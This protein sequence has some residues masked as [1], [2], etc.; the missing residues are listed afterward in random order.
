MLH[1]IWIIIKLGLLVAGAIWLT[2]RPGSVDIH[3]QTAT[4][5]YDITIQF[6]FFLFLLFLAILLSVGLTRGILYFKTLALRWR[7]RKNEKDVEKGLNAMTLSL[8]SAAAGD[9]GYCLFHAER[10]EKMLPGK[11]PLPVLLHAYALRKQGDEVQAN[12]LLEDLLDHREGSVLAARALVSHS[13]QKNDTGRALHYV[14]HAYD[15]YKGRDKAWL[16][17]TLYELEVR[18]R[19]WDEGEKLLKKLEAKKILTY[20]QVKSDR[21][22]LWTAK[23]H[24]L[25]LSAE[26]EKAIKQYKKVLKLDAGYVP[27]ALYVSRLYMERGE[28]KKVKHVLE[29][30]WKFSPH[31]DLADMWMRVRLATQS[32]KSQLEWAQ[33]LTAHF[34]QHFESYLVRIRAMMSEEKWSE[35]QEELNKAVSIKAEQRLYKIW[36]ELDERTGKSEATIRMRLEQMVEAFPPPCWTCRLTG[37]TYK[38]WAPLA[39]PHQSFN[40]IIWG[41][42]DEIRN[43]ALSLARDEEISSLDLL[44]AA[45]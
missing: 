29:T 41:Y 6:G 45:S 31:P 42:R 40:S 9:Q 3:W 13:L 28:H 19:N 24:E 18:Q 38:E 15:G 34:P 23:G 5:T 39:N 20:D 30:C 14:R 33:K 37:H 8:S 21:L 22:T 32:K 44:T 43:N 35:A 27:A 26:P 25:Q 7:N 16:L 36:A 17:K 1:I 11:Q 2:Y 10:A 4:D 12:A